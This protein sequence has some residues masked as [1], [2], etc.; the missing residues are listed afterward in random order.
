VVFGTRADGTVQALGV[1]RVPGE[2]IEMHFRAPGPGMMRM[3]FLP[4]QF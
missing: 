1:R 4:P 2:I 3:R